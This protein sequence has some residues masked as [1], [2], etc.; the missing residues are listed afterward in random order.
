MTPCCVALGSNLNGPESQVLGAMRALDAL[1]ETNIIAHSS[2]Y[3]SQPQGPQN[4][5][6]FINAVSLMHTR[7]DPVSLLLALQAIEQQMGRIKT[8][9]WG[10][11]VIDL[12]L[13][14]Y[15]QRQ[16]SNANPALTIP[17]PHALERDFVV[18]PLLEI[19]PDWQLPNGDYLSAHMPHCTS[20][21]LVKLT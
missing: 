3:L 21:D 6:P 14:F 17:H 9:H 16:V 7:L 8:R 19:A 4:Q 10:E 18:L 5:P 1:P 11:R 12:D 13:I 20:H 15:G 2:L